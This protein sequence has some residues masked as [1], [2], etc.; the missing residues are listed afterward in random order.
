MTRESTLVIAEAGVNHNGDLDLA[1]RLIDAA[2][3]AGAD[4][5]KFQTFSAAKIVTKTADKAEYQNKNLGGAESQQEMLERL[6]LSYEMHVR[7]I[8]HCKRRGIGFFSTGFD[9]DSLKL[10]IELGLERIKIPSGE[11]TNL[12]FLRFV[13]ALGKPVILSSGMANLG[14]VESAIN[15]LTAAGLAR[16]YICVL[17]CNSEYPTP[18]EDVNLRAMM[19]IKQALNVEVGYSD[20]TSGISIP[21]A[22]VALGAKVIEKH[23]TLDRSLPGPD[24]QASLE[25]AD[26]KLMVAGIRDIEKAL[27]DGVKRPSRSEQKNISVIRK[28]LVAATPIGKGE[29]L[30]VRNVTAKRPGSGIS[31]MRWDE[32]EHR[33]AT[34][35]YAKDELIEF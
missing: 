4:L 5:V 27:G 11:I 12:F 18:V 32:L 10:L 13:G 21:I 17:H 29:H 19:G 7:L 31:P 33:I 22:A 34:R 23:L 24:H 6:E 35:D 25:P 1:E 16:K 9:N 20:H 26:F 14:E 2:A 28:S 30:S 3:E 15:V 8:S